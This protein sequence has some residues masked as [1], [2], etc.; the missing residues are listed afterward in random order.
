M[1]KIFEFKIGT[2]IETTLKGYSC[3]DCDYCAVCDNCPVCEDCRVNRYYCD[4]CDHDVVRDY[5]IRHGYIN[6]DDDIDIC[7]ICQ[8]N[9]LWTEIICDGCDRCVDCQFVRNI[10]YCPY[11][12]E[13]LAETININEIEPY[14]DTFYN[15]GSCGLEFPTKAFNSL[16]DY[17]KAIKTIVST[18]GTEYIKTKDECGGHINISWKNIKN[19]K[20][21]KDYEFLIAKNIIFF[22]DLLSFMFNSRYTYYRYTWAKMPG[23]YK[24]IEDFI[25]DKYNYPLVVIK[26]DRIEIRFPDAVNS[27][28]NHTLLTAVLLSI[29][30]NTDNYLFE[31]NFE[32]TKE[33]YE[34]IRYYGDEPNRKQL[35][36]LKD[37][38]ILLRRIVKPYL[39]EFSHE[40]NVDLIKALD[41]RFKNPRFTT[42][43]KLNFK[44]FSM[45]KRI[46]LNTI[47]STIQK[48][49]F[50]FC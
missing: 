10:E 40:L 21:H 24:E 11:S 39:M 32:I 5:A 22:S 7:E 33:I 35:S 42:M 12:D 41:W 48:P 34:T 18:I 9:L 16:L 30:F 45:D 28:N 26:D 31:R 20:T 50:A 2:E 47:A 4:C 17:Y 13:L 29:S 36:I 37:K 43:K 3:D 44:M 25:I 38:Y 46:K 15:D 23:S 27:P 49:L 6:E 1:K 19:G 14:I 8:E